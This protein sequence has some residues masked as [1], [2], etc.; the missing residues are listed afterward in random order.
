MWSCIASFRCQGQ[1]D[2]K[3]SSNRLVA[4]GCRNGHSGY[5]CPFREPPVSVDPIA[6]VQ[7]KLRRGARNPFAVRHVIERPLQLEVLVDIAANLLEALAC[8][9]EALVEFRS[10]LDLGF[11]EGHLHPAVRVDF[12][13]ARGL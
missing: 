2:V 10:G 11:S 12:T 1:T 7:D 13:F 6:D 8:R 3:L 9:F 5:A 4:G